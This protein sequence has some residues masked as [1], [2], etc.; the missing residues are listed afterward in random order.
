MALSVAFKNQSLMQ[1][2][3][4]EEPTEAERPVKKVV[5][6]SIYTLQREQRFL[7]QALKKYSG[8]IKEIQKYIPG[9]EPNFK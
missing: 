2:V 3:P 4:L 1:A 5:P 9:W 8:R 6:K 7:K